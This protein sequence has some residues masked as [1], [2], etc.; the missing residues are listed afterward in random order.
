MDQMGRGKGA[1]ISGFDALGRFNLGVLSTTQANQQSEPLY[2][3]NNTRNGALSAGAAPYTDPARSRGRTGIT[4]IRTTRTALPAAEAARQ[5]SGVA[6][7]LSGR[8]AARLASATG[9]RIKANGI[10]R[11]AE[12]PTVACISAFRR[13]TGRRT[14]CPTPI[15]IRSCPVRPLQPPDA[16]GSG[17]A[18]QPPQNLR[19]LTGTLE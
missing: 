4:T 6:H 3:W 10:Q 5:A 14:T 16:S 2:I 18:P 8:R 1:L 19:I 7:S 15:L 12:H 17:S 11:T 13:T 9:P